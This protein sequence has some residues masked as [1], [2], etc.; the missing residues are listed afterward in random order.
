[1]ILIQLS[2]RLTAIGAS[3]VLGDHALQSHQ[4]GVPELVRTGSRPARN[5]QGG[6]RRRA[7]PAAGQ[8]DPA[9]RQRLPQ[10]LAAS[11]QDIECVELHLGIVSTR[12]QPVE[13]GPAVDAEQ[14][15][16]AIE[17]KGGVAVTKRGLDG[18]GSDQSWPFRV[19]SRTRLPSRWTACGWPSQDRHQAGHWRNSLRVLVPFRISERPSLFQRLLAGQHTRPHPPDWTIVP[20]E[21]PGWPA[22]REV[23]LIAP[24]VFHA[25]MPD[26]GGHAVCHAGHLGIELLF[27]TP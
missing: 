25:L 6:C 13:I 5:R 24:E 2:N 18:S 9:H 7:A 10:V 8:V 11:R 23:D 1:L 3:A 19:H 20:I 4:A 16:F 12:V 26:D 21:E 27:P 17:D 15:G 14:H 22:I